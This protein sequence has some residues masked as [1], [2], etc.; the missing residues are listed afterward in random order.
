MLNLA[1][2]LGQNKS[3]L[4]TSPSK[5]T[6]TDDSQGTFS[7]RRKAN[8]AEDEESESTLTEKNEEV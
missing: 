6:N 2:Q 7:K 1:L 8:S 4:R 5:R 3:Y